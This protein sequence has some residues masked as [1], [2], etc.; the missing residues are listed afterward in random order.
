MNELNGLPLLGSLK[1]LPVALWEHRIDRVVIDASTTPTGDR[2]LGRLQA[3][4]DRLGALGKRTLYPT[5][6]AVAL[7]GECGGRHF[8]LHC[9]SLREL[10]GAHHARIHPSIDFSPPVDTRAKG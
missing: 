1:N 3:A 6:G 2:L 5:A 9:R 10:C 7:Q 8:T 4:I